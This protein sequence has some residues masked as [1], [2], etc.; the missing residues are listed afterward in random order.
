M[1]ASADLIAAEDTRHS[2]QLLAALGLSR[3]MI[4]LHD[5]NERARVAE[6]LQRLSAGERVALISDAGTPLV[7]DPGFL[8][9]RAAIEAGFNVVAIPGP[10][11][12]LTALAV[13]GLPTDRFAFEGFLPAKSGERRRLLASLVTASHTLVFFESPHR[14]A[15]SLADQAELLGGERQ[16]LVARELTKL[17]E[18]LYRG[19]LAQLALRAASEPNLARGELTLVVQGAPPGAT[20]GDEALLRRALPLL[21][22]ELP[23]ARAAAIAAQLAGVP[24]RRAYALALELG[25]RRGAMEN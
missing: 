5:H 2:A 23:A 16:A 12:V 8:L 20:E 3:P 15:A 17:H 25:G 9:V 21:L 13:A 24:R 22:A 4:S 7:S 18:T 1:L 10:S 6:I 11:A 14:I 19:T